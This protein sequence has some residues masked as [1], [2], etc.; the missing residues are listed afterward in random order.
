MHPF[1]HQAQS[2]VGQPIYVHAHG[3]V[4][5]GVLHSI[6]SQGIYLRPLNSARTVSMHDEQT[7]EIVPLPLSQQEE[8][9]AEPIFWAL[10][11][12]PWFAILALGP[13]WW[14]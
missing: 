10:F 4:H 11:F 5:H 12:I 6:N 7:T 3:R 13:W 1:Y 14:W 2:L 9:Q 8:I